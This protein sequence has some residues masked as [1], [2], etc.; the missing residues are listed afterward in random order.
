MLASLLGIRPEDRR[1]ATFA[2]L[3]LLGL[4]TAHSLLET[5]RDTL[6]L[7]HL[8]ARDLPLAYVAIAVIAFLIAAVSR[9]FEGAVPRRIALSIALVLGGAITASFGFWVTSES[10]VALISLYVWTGVLA[11][12][13]VVQFWLL[14]AHA[15]DFGQAKR[16]FAIIGAGGLVGAVLGSATAGG[17]LM[18]VAPSSLLFVSGSIFA[19]TA[20]LPQFLT[21]RRAAP[22]AKPK[23]IHDAR[24][25][26]TLLRE[27]P[28][29]R[30]MLWV[31]LLSSMLFTGVDF[32]FKAQASVDLAPDQLGPF[33]AR[34]YAVSSVLALLVQVFAAPRLLRVLGVNGSLLVLPSLLLVSS[35]GFVLTGGL[36]AALLMRGTD[37]TLRHSLH[38]TGT[39]ILSVPLLPA[40]RERFKGFVEAVGQRG[41]RAS[42]RSCSSRRPP[43]ARGH[44]RSAADS[45]RSPRSGSSCRAA[46][47]RTTSSSSGETSGKASSRRTSKF[48]IST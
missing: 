18:M 36:G 10:M 22:G 16:T 35:A 44:C 23:K 11:T 6:F 8:P 1:V 28:Y 34:F 17:L 13:V 20:V 4:M 21:M 25:S 41:V 33:F 38:R 12:I 14:V 2:F 30:R 3:T 26:F 24:P 46:S 9:R 43:S 42:R 40:V 47:S 39:E 31:A 37:G 27:E 29:L 32:V 19:V 45:S 5:A 48:R 15:L 7:S